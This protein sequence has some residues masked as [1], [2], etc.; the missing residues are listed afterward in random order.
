MFILEFDV[1]Q[2][3]AQRPRYHRSCNSWAANGFPNGVI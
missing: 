2:R 1:M 3:A